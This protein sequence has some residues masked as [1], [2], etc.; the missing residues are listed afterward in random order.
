MAKTFKPEGGSRQNFNNLFARLAALESGHTRLMDRVTQL[1]TELF[2]QQETIAAIR[3]HEN[4]D[5]AALAA[6]VDGGA[7]NLLKITASSSGDNVNFTV[8]GNGTITVD[9]TAGTSNAVFVVASRL[10]I[11]AGNYYISMFDN[12][13]YYSNNMYISAQF[14]DTPSGSPTWSGHEYYTDT[15]I[16]PAGDILA[17]A[18]VVKAGQTISQTVQ[19]MICTAEDYAIS[20]AFVPYRPSWQELYE[21]IL[22]LQS[23][24]ASTQSVQPA[25]MSAAKAET[26]EQREEE[27]TDA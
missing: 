8:N 26:Q 11:P 24:G 1:Y 22:A 19:P 5:R 27:E 14:K 13:A 20:P 18:I 16:N 12:S 2:T 25:L 4:E 21:M 6:L 10:T 17:V 23:G 7:K 15:Q 3:T 9:G